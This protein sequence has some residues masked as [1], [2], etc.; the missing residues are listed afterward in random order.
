MNFDQTLDRRGTDS[1]KWEVAEG[2]LPMGLAD[3]DF[4][5]V[6]E[7]KEAILPG[8]ARGIWLYAGV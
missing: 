1:M 2:Q 5:T 4:E 7:V 3:M 6:P 8:T